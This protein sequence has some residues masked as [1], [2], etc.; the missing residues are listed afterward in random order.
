MQQAV[1]QENHSPMRHPDFLAGSSGE[2]KEK[3][4]ADQQ[5]AM[6]FVIGINHK[7]AP[8]SV[9]ERLT[10]HPEES[11]A[12][13]ARLLRL[14]DVQEIAL[15]STCNRTEIYGV[16]T[17]ASMQAIR[18]WL[19]H[20]HPSPAQLIQHLYL[21]EQTEAV[22]HLLHVAAGLDSM[23]L[24]E[25]QILGQLKQAYRRAQQA[26]TLGRILKRAFQ[27]AFAAAKQARSSTGI[28][29]NPISVAFAAVALAKQLFESLSQQTVLML[30]AGET[31]ELA[32]RHLIAYQPAHIYIVNRNLAKARELAE[33]FGGTGLGLGDLP[34]VLPKADIVIASTASPLPLLGKGMVESALKKRKFRPMFM[35][36]LAVPR[37]IEPEVGQLRDVYL[38]TVDDLQKIVSDNQR[39]RQEAAKEA[40]KLLESQVQQFMAWLLSLKNV[41]LI[42]A[43]RDH[44]ES[45][46]QQTLE[47]ALKMLQ[48]GKS[49]EECL[50]FLANT[51]T[52]RL[53]HLPTIAIREAVHSQDVEK[54]KNI[55]QLFHLSK[56][57]S[58][59]P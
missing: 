16:G 22:R 27:V 29:A 39:A 47:Q 23:V 8:L 35:I 49:A 54:I 56:K 52:N 36:D 42:C 59:D 43:Y 46:R 55:E 50:H 11:E 28:G 41:T 40:A 6:L 44:A 21:H 26:K 10:F 15:L 19:A 7:T 1:L 20:L 37:D 3:T 5:I 18:D 38:Y 58:S 33:Q 17:S 25:P 4:K 31:I 32:V 45:L 2:D 30:G 53:A 12:T 51:L 57:N 9:R 13:F 24:G 48:K 34:E 14:P